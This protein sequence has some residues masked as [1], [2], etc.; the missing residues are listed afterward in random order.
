MAASKEEEAMIGAIEIKEIPS[1]LKMKDKQNASNNTI[2]KSA[3]DQ[4]I[5][6][7]ENTQRQ[8]VFPGNNTMGGQQ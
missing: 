1:N 8:I 4:F 7:T 2:P 6:T 5:M 3:S